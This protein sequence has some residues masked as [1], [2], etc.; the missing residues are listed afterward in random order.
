MR[1]LRTAL[2]PLFVLVLV[3]APV[4]THAAEYFAAQVRIQNNSF[5]DPETT[6]EPTAQHTYEVNGFYGVAYTRVIANR[7]ALFVQAGSYKPQPFAFG[8]FGSFRFD[9]LVFSCE[10]G[11]A[12]VT[13][14]L[15]LDVSADIT[16]NG[17]LPDD[18]GGAGFTLGD[19]TAA[20][21]SSFSTWGAWDWQ[22]GGTNVLSGLS[23][24]Y[25]VPQTRITGPARTVSTG[26]QVPLTVSARAGGG[27]NKGSFVYM[28]VQPRLPTDG[29]VFDLPEGCTCNSQEGYIFDS[30]FY[31]DGNPV[32]LVTVSGVISS[33]C[34]GPL[35]GAEVTLVDTEGTS[36]TVTTDASGAYSFA[37]VVGGATGATL[38][39]TAPAGYELVAA[40][41]GD[42]AV[43]LSADLVRDFQLQCTYVTVSGVVSACEGPLQGVTVDFDAD[44][45][46][47]AAE[48]QTTSTDADGAYTFS[49]VRWSEEAAELSIVTPLG[50][51]PVA[52]VNGHDLVALTADQ[53]LDFQVGCLVAQGEARGMGYWKHQ[54]KAHVKAKGHPHE[55]LEDMETTYPQA[56]FNHFF[57]NQLNGIAVEGVT[58]VDDG[59]TIRALGLQEIHATLTVKGNVAMADRAKQHYLS[60]LLNVASGRLLSS[61]VISDDGATLSQAVQQVASYLN[62]GDPA[63]D[64]TAKDIAETLNHAQL[65]AISVIDLT[66]D[67]IA[68]KQPSS[69]ISFS[70]RPARNPFP[71]GTA[72]RLALPMQTR[73]E[74]SIHDVRGRTL[75]TLTG[76][77]GPGIVPVVWDGNDGSGEPVGRGVYL[78][79]VRADLHSA[80][81]KITLLR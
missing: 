39:V 32:T 6:T 24:G 29:P 57:E 47:P 74:V 3:Q 34:D 42:Q 28:R 9:D 1:L 4:P 73:Y 7:G 79:R 45:L 52:P 78:Y 13:Y 54:A 26:L 21:G 12:N 48:M 8:A 71:A 41:T 30:R 67:D 36:S 10:D 49:G 72:I 2:L 35:A 68:Y 61:S 22:N 81:G 19:P 18:I 51:E 15:N 58:Y 63:N 65:L 40:D 14:R 46:D 44:P 50:Y 59:G 25:S 27:S 70:A 80:S 11:R 62:D 20:Y 33:D 69:T 64:E 16:G 56:I 5:V 55:T 38:S 75:R 76:S 37:D 43:D 77:A 31:P 60:L 23:A 17:V 66:L 53:T